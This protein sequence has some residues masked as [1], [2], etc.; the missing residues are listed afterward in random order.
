MRTVG[1]LVA[2]FAV[3]SS[4]TV[5][6]TAA[7]RARPIDRPATVAVPAE[8]GPVVELT[9][10]GAPP[11]RCGRVIV[12]GDSLTDNAS[13]W[14]TRGLREAGYTAH[15]DAQ[16]SREI[17]GR[18]PPP[19]SGTAAARAARATFGEADCWVIALGSN[20][21]LH[22]NDAATAGALV[23]TLLAEVS[24]GARVWWTNVDF[25]R[26]PR[27]RI[28]FPGRTAIF[29]AELDA[30]AAAG[31][32]VV[33][34][35]YSYAEANLHWFFDPVHVDRAGSIARAAQLVAALG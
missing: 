28:D 7:V 4:A 30:R 14:L 21:L 10:P 19:Y 16:P 15:V 12:I 17:G 9:S 13:P 8:R 34:D 27:Y 3:C 24:P 18:R 32:L 2:W 35:W 5:G 25:H 11:P 31:R 29:N 23:D 1:R 26:D 22:L 33:I 20:D 6:V